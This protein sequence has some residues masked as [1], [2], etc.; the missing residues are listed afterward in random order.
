MVLGIQNS[1]SLQTSTS[2]EG[3]SQNS[4]RYSALSDDDPQEEE[5]SNATTAVLPVGEIPEQV[6]DQSAI[7]RTHSHESCDGSKGLDNV[8]L[9][10]PA[11]PTPGEHENQLTLVEQVEEPAE[12]AKQQSLE[13]KDFHEASSE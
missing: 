12:E 1:P 8:S 5:S 11:A 7:V 3:G 10:K 9:D 6:P 4:N 2:S 13:E